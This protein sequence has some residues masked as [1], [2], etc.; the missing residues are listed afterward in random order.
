MWYSVCLEVVE[1]RRC[2][3]EVP[4][5]GVMCTALYA[6]GVGGAGDAVGD[7]PARL[8]PSKLAPSKLAPS[9]LA[10]SRL[11]PSRRILGRAFKVGDGSRSRSKVHHPDFGSRFGSWPLYLAEPS[12]ELAALGCRCLANRPVGWQYDGFVGSSLLEVEQQ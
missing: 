11:A 8:V 5:G 1:G 2:L 6:G 9:R 7:A 12:R 3:L 4:E 10:P